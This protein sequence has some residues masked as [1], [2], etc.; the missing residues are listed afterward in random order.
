MERW[1]DVVEIVAAYIKNMREKGVQKWVFDE[2]ANIE[3]MK[4]NFRSK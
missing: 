1:V 2:I 3:R 4:F